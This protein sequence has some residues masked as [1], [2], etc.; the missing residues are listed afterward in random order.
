MKTYSLLPTFRR[1]GA[2]LGAGLC[3]LA[4]LLPAAEKKEPPLE[5]YIDLSAGYTTQTGDRPAFQKAQQFKKE[6]FGGIE[7]L[8]ITTA[9]NDSTNFVFQGHALAGNN[10]YLLDFAITK[11]EVGF[12]KFGYREYR[13]WYNGRAGFLPSTGF[14]RQL[15][16]NDLSIDRG[17]LWF[18]AGYIAPDRPNL[19]LRYDLFTRKGTKDSLS[20]G[21]TGLAVNASNLRGLLP[22]FWKIDE[23]RHQFVGDLSKTNEKSNWALGVRVD[24]GDYTNTRNENRRAGEAGFDRKVTQKESQDYD[25]FQMRGSYVNQ[26]HEKL[27]VTTAVA[28]TTIDTTISGS[29]IYGQDYDPI[30]DAAFLNRQQRDEG[31]FGLHGKAEMKQTIANI[32]ARYQPTENLAIVPAVRFEKIDWSNR[33]DFEETNFS[34]TKLPI[35]DEVEAESE[36]DWKVLAESLEVRYTGWKNVSLNFKGEWTDSKGTLTEDRILEPG[37]PLQVVSIDRDTEFQRKTQKYAAT[38]NWY[39]RPGTTVAVQYYY[40]VRTNDFRSTRDTTPNT[41][42]SGDRYPA[43]IANQDFETNDFNVRL[44]TKLA[45]NLRSVTRYDY[46]TTTIRTQDVSLPMGESANMTS[47]ILAETLTWNPQPRWYVQ[48]GINLVWDTFN[49]PAVGLTG[50]A[51]DLVKNADANYTSLNLGSG[52][53]LDERSDIYFDYSLTQSKDS[54]IDNSART[55]AYGSEAKTQLASVT[56]NRKLDRR[57]SV[58]LKYAYA[59]NED[60]PSGGFAN[61]EAHML[62]G[63][64]Q[65]RF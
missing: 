58:T 60:V 43:Y 37:T 34:A 26:I 33:V 14:T 40:K 61:Y 29:R 6:G 64:V 9:I 42:T 36:K 49:T 35:N 15:Y 7:G 16:D 27:M 55:V 54:F 2:L 47:H 62:Y 22:S 1:P 56:W 12:L 23:K 59:K 46:Q 18:E 50:A 8:Y 39:A 57:T 19:N 21:D 17:N 53:A 11:D 5:N 52:Y 51:A 30:Y 41:L 65:Y 10:D 48:A 28:R 13:V 24:R 3:L 45:P 25:L 4:G 63:K 38:T 44:S 20:W 32:S 31:F